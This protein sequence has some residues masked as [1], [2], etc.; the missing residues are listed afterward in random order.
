[1]TVQRGFTASNINISIENAL[2]SN[3]KC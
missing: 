1:V 3:Y 2:L